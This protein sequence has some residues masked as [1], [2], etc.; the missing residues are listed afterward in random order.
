MKILK[1]LRAIV[2]SNQGGLISG[3][4]ILFY[5][6]QA[7]AYVGPGL[8]LGVI[9]AIIGTVVAVILAI[10]GLVW[11][12]IKSAMKKKKAAGG[13]P[14]ESMAANKES[15]HK[16]GNSEHSISAQA[17]DVSSESLSSENMPSENGSSPNSSSQN[18]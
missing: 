10:F 18:R 8:G 13:A 16:E 14:L 4:A 11:Y 12:P 7:S 3:I 17:H 2:M 1:H 5:C 15:D 9:G 6:S